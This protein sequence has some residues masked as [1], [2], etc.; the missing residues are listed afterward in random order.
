LSRRKLRTEAAAL[1][2]LVVVVLIPFLD[3]LFASGRF[4]VRD[5]TRCP[6]E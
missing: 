5:L 3:V 6:A 4:Y 2:L 1:T